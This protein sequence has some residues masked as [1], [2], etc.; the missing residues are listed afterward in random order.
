MTDEVVDDVA[1]EPWVP[2][3][4]WHRPWLE[5]RL[6]ERDRLHH[7]LLV[8]GPSGIG[9]KIL[10]LNFA[11]ALL[12]ET[13]RDAGFACGTCAGCRYVAARTHPDLRVLDLFDVDEDDG[14]WKTVNEIGIKR[15][16]RLTEMLEI[17]SHRAGR[18]V[19]VI[20]PAERMTGEAANALLKTLEEPPP[21]TTLLLVA[22]RPGRL[23]PTVVSRCLR[24]PAPMPAHDEAIA[25][26]ESRGT[27]DASGALAEAGGAPLA[28]LGLAD[29]EGRAERKAWFDALAHPQ[30]LVPIAIGARID[31]AGKDQRKPRL[32]AG[33]DALVA[34]TADLARVSAGGSAQRLPAYQPAL[35]ALAPRVARIGL[36]RYHRS[37]L[38]QRAWIAHPLAPRLVA[39][40]LLAEYRA[41]FA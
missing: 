34:W 9:K 41:L 36:C 1:P 12:C 28:A 32:A 40:A 27:S 14:C 39:E 3:L 22:H 8:T 37:V 17:S 21:D 5:A 29:A 31:A 23:L 30:R 19:A 6:R 35:A 15:V 24:V 2:P 20:A 4:P 26:L 38:F 10:A 18:R 11:Q 16:R 33:L 13:P 25:W 7:A